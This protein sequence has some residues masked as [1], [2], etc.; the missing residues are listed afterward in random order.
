MTIKTI[1]T[2]VDDNDHDG[3]S[4]DVTLRLAATYSAHLIGL[5]VKPTRYVPGYAMEVGLVPPE[6]VLMRDPEPVAA[7]AADRFSRLAGRA[8]IIDSE[9]R[10]D[11]GPV[12]STLG[13]HGRYAD[14][15]V[16][17]Q[18]TPGTS[19]SNAPADFPAL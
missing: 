14:L 7:R 5:H 11:E 1:L 16:V 17:E 18:P 4:L 19:Y 3:G 9:W 12:V 15:I 6:T 2:H 10:I 13:R 8:G